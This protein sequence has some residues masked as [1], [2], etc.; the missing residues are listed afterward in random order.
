MPRIYPS[1]FIASVL[2]ILLLTHSS[3]SSARTEYDIKA[4]YLYNFIKFVTWP[5][6]NT[7]QAIKVCLF[8]DH[9]VNEKLMPLSE[10]TLNQRAIE[11]I[12]INA[13]EDSVSCSVL[14]I[15][16]SEAKQLAQLLSVLENQATL[17]ISD[18][19]DFAQQGG[20]IGFVTMGNVIRFDVNLKQARAIG[21]SISSKLLEL[22]NEV[23][24]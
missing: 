23:L 7:E 21:L 6:Q 10:V 2:G 4:A 13:V 15:A 20:Q 19:E 11:V 8:G 3:L 17:T 5:E 24:K 22:A 1:R 16:P 14:F 12:E 9:P 18:M